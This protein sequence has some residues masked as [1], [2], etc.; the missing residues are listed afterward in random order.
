M[1]DIQ[2]LLFDTETE[3]LE[4]VSRCSHTD[5]I[6][7][8]CPIG[9]YQVQMIVPSAPLEDY[10]YKTFLIRNSDIF[11][12]HYFHSDQCIPHDFPEDYRELICEILENYF[13]SALINLK[14]SSD[15][16]HGLYTILKEKEEE[17]AKVAQPQPLLF[18][19]NPCPSP[20]PRSVGVDIDKMMDELKES[21]I[22]RPG[23]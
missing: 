10:Y 18:A 7:A 5:I 6:I 14:H 1:A 9:A 19:Y 21:D 3:L 17:E 22:N 4:S 11:K 16:N 20:I 23:V 13:M 12:T 2:Y 8:I 15:V